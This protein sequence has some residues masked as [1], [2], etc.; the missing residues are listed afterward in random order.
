[1]ENVLVAVGVELIFFI[2]LGGGC[3]L[4]F[5]PELPLVPLKSFCLRW[6]ATCWNMINQFT[7]VT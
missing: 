6:T 2:V 1:M 5:E 4:D 7:G 3:V